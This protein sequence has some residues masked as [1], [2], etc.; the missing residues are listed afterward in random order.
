MIGGGLD[1]IQNGNALNEIPTKKLG[2]MIDHGK[3]TK[4]LLMVLKMWT[5]NFV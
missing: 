5:I 2:K 3:A 4:I 1:A